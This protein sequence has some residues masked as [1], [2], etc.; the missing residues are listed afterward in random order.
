MTK[1]KIDQFFTSKKYA[2]IGVS[3]DK[4]KFGG[5]LYKEYVKAGFD[6]VPVNPGLAEFEGNKC[7][8]SVN[9]LPEEVDAL[10]VPT[11]PKHTINVLKDAE[12]KG[13]KQVWLQQGSEDEYCIEYAE[14]SSMNVIYKKCAIMFGNPKGIHGFH[15]FLS[16]VFGKYPK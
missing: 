16:K 11:K 1:E 6:V 15:A 9:E 14:K 5:A 3:N 13:I 2:V 10:I 8:A 7:Y 4:K 12:N